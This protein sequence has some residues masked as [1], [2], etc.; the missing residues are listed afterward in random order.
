MVASRKIS[1][2]YIYIP[3]KYIWTSTPIIVELNEF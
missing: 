3:A 1:I 2:R